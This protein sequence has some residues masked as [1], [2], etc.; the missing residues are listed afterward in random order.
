MI[1]R[2]SRWWACLRARAP[3]TNTTIVAGAK[4]T[5]SDSALVHVPARVAVAV[6]RAEAVAELH[7]ARR[8]AALG[9]F[10]A[11]IA[12]DIRTPLTSISL[13]VQI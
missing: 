2:S 4:N 6:Q 9:Q 12:H 11:A 13:N 8:L 1:T 10:A 7:D 3:R 5:S